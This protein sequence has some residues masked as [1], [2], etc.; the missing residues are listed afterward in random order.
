MKDFVATYTCNVCSYRWEAAYEP[1]INVMLWKPCPK[2]GTKGLFGGT[3]WAENCRTK[4]EGTLR[5]EGSGGVLLTLRD[6]KIS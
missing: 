3:G 4:P 1:R 2:C 5:L 6:E